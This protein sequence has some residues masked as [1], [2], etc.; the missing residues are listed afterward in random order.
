[1]PPDRR[2]LR[3]IRSA[4]RG[5]QRYQVGAGQWLLWFRFNKAG[6]TSDPTYGTGPTRAWFPPITVPAMIGE[7][8]RDPKNF[9]DDG[10]YQVDQVHAILNYFDFFSSTMID[11]DPNGQDHVND[12]V[13]FDGHLFSVS[14]FTP[15]G[16]VASYFLTISVDMIEIAAEELNEDPISSL[17]SPYLVAS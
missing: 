9:D 7:Y 15:R 16:R 1:M 3:D 4:Y 8:T 11:P 6:T 12:R 13:V 14:S 2:L 10:L 17:F 5:M